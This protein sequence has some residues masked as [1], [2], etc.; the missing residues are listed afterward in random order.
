MEQPTG[1]AIDRRERMPVRL[2][3]ADV[4]ALR[5]AAALFLSEPR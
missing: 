3:M 2:S 4:E 1:R 5:R